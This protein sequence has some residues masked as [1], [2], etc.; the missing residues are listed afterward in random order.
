LDNPHREWKARR[1]KGE[2][3]NRSAD[4]TTKDKK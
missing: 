3:E 1:K 2:H 4:E